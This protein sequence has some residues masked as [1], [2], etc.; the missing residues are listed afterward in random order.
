MLTPGSTAE[1]VALSFLIV[2]G[3]ALLISDRG[4]RQRTLICLAEHAFLALPP[5]VRMLLN[6][7]SIPTSV[8]DGIVSVEVAPDT[9]HLILQIGEAPAID[10]DAEYWAAE[11]VA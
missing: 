1:I 2:T 9:W 5:G 6:E 11:P 3:V 8:K 4:D 7:Q 10:D